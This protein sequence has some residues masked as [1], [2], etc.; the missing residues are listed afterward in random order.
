MRIVH[1]YPHAAIPS[2]VTAA[3]FGWASAVRA[4]GVQSAILHQ[5]G[6]TEP[7]TDT[8][9]E[10]IAHLGTKRQTRL[11]VGLRSALHR[12]DVL[13]LHEG[14]VPSNYYAG[15]VARQMKVPYVVTPHGVYEPAI[16]RHLM[17]PR[18]G[19]E[20]LEADLLKHAAAV[21]VFFPSEVGLVKSIC[22][23]AN[24][25]V[26]PTGIATPTDE[27]RGDAGYL[28]WFGRYDPAHKGLDHLLL[29]LSWMPAGERPRLLLRG[30][31]FR[32]GKA[33]VHRMVQE[34][35]LRPWVELGA[36]VND[37]EK[38]ALLIHAGA[39]VHPSRWESHSVAL[40]ESLALG[41]PCIVSRY[42]HIASDLQ[43]SGAA[44]VSDLGPSAL[45]S[46]ITA[47]MNAGTVGRA[48]RTYVETNLNW[49][50]VGRQFM[51][52]LEEALW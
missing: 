18:W 25:I 1:Y 6:H 2:G 9:T 15:W 3:I 40:L 20:A 28:T 32:G 4:L 44:N 45:A 5:P 29:A 48:G 26:A 52:Q 42:I 43:A 50:H 16:R 24:V 46:A 10:A 8:P 47:T 37:V 34:L 27:W 22:S 23:T 21:H 12:G 31:D 13:V 14:W 11:P 33:V 39:Y 51:H 38:T 36:Y 41:V 35:E 17:R 30:Y 19:R 49:P 7:A